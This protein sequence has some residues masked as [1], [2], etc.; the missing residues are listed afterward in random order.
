MRVYTWDGTQLAFQ[1]FISFL[2]K[3]LQRHS[4]QK[5]SIQIAELVWVT[6]NKP[7][8]PKSLQPDCHAG[9]GISSLFLLGFH[10]I[11][12]NLQGWSPVFF[13]SSPSLCPSLSH[14]GQFGSATGARHPG[15]APG[16]GHRKEKDASCTICLCFF[17][18]S[19]FVSSAFVICD[20][21]FVNFDS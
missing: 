11:R 16:I 8:L 4:E 5:A 20:L 2:Y 1:V 3:D 7:L 19:E 13:Q 10:I 9:I 17:F 6:N 18:T 14:L 21:W 12:L 15:E